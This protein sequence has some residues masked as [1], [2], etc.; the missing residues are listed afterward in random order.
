M[1]FYFVDITGG[2]TYV[3]YMNMSCSKGAKIKG[4]TL[5]VRVE[6]IG[7]S[8]PIRYVAYFLTSTT[9]SLAT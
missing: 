6:L 3:I 1:G 5:L 4:L 8:S 7:I 9:I 2:V